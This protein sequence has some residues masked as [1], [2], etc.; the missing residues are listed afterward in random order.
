MIKVLVTGDRSN[1]N[2]GY[3]VYKKNLLQALHDHPDFEAA[4]LAYSGY[5]IH[6][7]EVPWRY[8]PSTV[9]KNDKEYQNYLSNVENKYGAWRWDQILLHFKPNI[10]ISPI[11][12]WQIKFQTTSPLRDFYHLCASPPIDSDPIKDQNVAILAEANS[13]VAY[14]NYGKKSMENAGLIVDKVIPMGVSS[15]DFYPLDEV[16]KL[17]NR[18]AFG[19][20]DNAI[21][22]GFVAR[23]QP[24]KRIPDLMAAFRVFLDNNPDLEDR[25][26]LYF[27]TTYP[28][29]D[30]WDIPKYL[31][32]YGLS[33][34]V[35]FTYKCTKTGMCFARKFS[36]KLV[37]CPFTG[38]ITGR[39]VDVNTDSP[40]IS[41]LNN[42]YNLFDVYIQAS[43]CEGFGSPIVEAA[44]CDL[45]TIV[46]SYSA[47][48][49]VG[50]SVGAI[51][52][53]PKMM[54]EDK[55]IGSYR[56]QIDI[57][58]L[59]LCMRKA[60]DNKFKPRETAISLYDWKT[61]CTDEWISYIKSLNLKDKWS[62]SKRTLLFEKINDGMPQVDIIT[63]TSSAFPDKYN[64]K[65]VAKLEELY[66]GGR[67]IGNEYMPNNVQN[68]IEQYKNKLK[69]FNYIENIRCGGAELKEEEWMK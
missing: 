47:M 45:S 39:I 16:K 22:F 26:I 49:E 2:T 52:N 15:K 66:H 34:K 18:R 6:K 48:K 21:V 60:L 59:A 32:R 55:S 56:A 3:A 23:N 38:S 17:E 68:T 20:P 36:D 65:T 35:L 1:A 69:Y 31:M 11:D 28:D 51:L 27:H 7:K 46:V 41:D 29:L 12:P 67:Y 57:E 58:D 25:A 19:V 13:L 8:Y 24:R 62:A 14:T 42:V 9:H 43:N 30:P 5:F 44:L 10:V 63:R 61:K 50:S 4:E 54:V 33:D 40:T 64:Y 37:Y 53:K